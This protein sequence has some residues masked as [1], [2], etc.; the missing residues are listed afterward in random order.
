MFY[1]F[2]SS[3][4]LFMAF[5]WLI[6]LANISKSVQERWSESPFSALCGCRGKHSIFATNWEGICGGFIDSL[7][8]W[9]HLLLTPVCWEFFSLCL[10]RQE[11]FTGVLSSHL[12]FP[13]PLRDV[14]RSPGCRIKLCVLPAGCTSESILR[15][16]YWSCVR[17]RR[18]LFA[19]Y[20]RSRYSS[21]VKE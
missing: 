1:L 5:S 8:D 18:K 19:E 21:I 13:P 6:A 14:F 7:S 4:M 10:R 20:L 16:H 12:F 2:F 9:R 11:V 3:W 15:K 17:H